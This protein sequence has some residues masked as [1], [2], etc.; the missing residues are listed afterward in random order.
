MV[1]VVNLYS[2][3]F[4]HFWRGHKNGAP[5]ASKQPIVANFHGTC[6]PRHHLGRLVVVDWHIYIYIY[7]KSHSQEDLAK[8]LGKV[9]CL[10]QFA[11][12]HHWKVNWWLRVSVFPSFQVWKI[13]FT[14]WGSVALREDPNYTNRYQ[15]CKH[16]K[17]SFEESYMWQFPKHCQSILL[18][19]THIFLLT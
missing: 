5:E 4:S 3:F 16:R 10:K 15:L 7:L 12:H 13:G 19:R 11:S 18:V 2:L 6:V 9:L 17:V 1:H 8:T 14:S